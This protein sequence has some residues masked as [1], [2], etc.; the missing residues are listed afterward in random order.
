MS[1]RR[2]WTDQ[3]LIEIVPTARSVSECLRRLG[4][5]ATGANYKSFYANVER[6]SLDIS[7]FKGQGYLKGESHNWNPKKPLD[8]ILVENSTYLNSANLKKRLLK[9]GLLIYKCL[10]CGIDSWGDNPLSLHL[11]HINGNNRDNRLENLRLLCPNCH[12]QTDT[13]AGKNK[14]VNCQ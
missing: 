12:S 2:T 11:D 7:H 5:K 8:E 4:L 13:Y 1:R 3:Q 6:L 14:G 10:V 9:A